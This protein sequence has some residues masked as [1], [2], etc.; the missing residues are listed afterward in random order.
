MARVPLVLVVGVHRVDDVHPFVDYVLDFLGLGFPFDD[1]D[2]EVM[3]EGEAVEEVV[4][5]VVVAEEAVAVVARGT[6]VLVVV[7]RR[8]LDDRCSHPLGCWVSVPFAV[9]VDVGVGGVLFQGV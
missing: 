6:L 2:V 5:V 7:A 9:C 8:F 3:V 1:D 4:A